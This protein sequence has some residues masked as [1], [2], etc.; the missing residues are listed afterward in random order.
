MILALNKVVVSQLL[1][2]KCNPPS[3][4]PLTEIVPHPMT[5]SKTIQQTRN[6]MS[7]I[8]QVPVTLKKEID[9]FALNRM[10]YAIINEA[11]RLVQVCFP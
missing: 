2:F 8:G 4:C 3:L 11:W 5:S 1:I 6:L 10:Q 7:E 9:G